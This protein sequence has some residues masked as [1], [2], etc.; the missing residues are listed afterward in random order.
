M[1]KILILLIC[2]CLYIN[3]QSIKAKR[4]VSSSTSVQAESNSYGANRTDVSPTAANIVSAIP[5][6]AVGSSFQFSIK[7]TAD[8][9]EELTLSAGSG[10]TV[11]HS[12]AVEIPEHITGPFLAVATNVT[13]GSEAVTIH[14]LIK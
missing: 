7:N 13:S 3:A 14:F 11:S 12:R 10:V 4:S 9:S 2:S 5:N 6:A 8:A 1:K